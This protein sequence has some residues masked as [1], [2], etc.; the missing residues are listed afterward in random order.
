M[1]L[2]IKVLSLSLVSFSCQTPKQEYKLSLMYVGTI[3]FM[4]LTLAPLLKVCVN[5][6][7][8]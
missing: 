6:M 3:L 8:T 7:L 1:T 4:L 5:R 2:Y